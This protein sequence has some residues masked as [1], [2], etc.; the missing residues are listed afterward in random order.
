M[1]NREALYEKIKNAPL[2]A[3]LNRGQV[4][5]LLRELNARLEVLEKGHMIFPRTEPIDS[6]ALILSGS[7]E[8]A[9]HDYWG[10]RS[11]ILTQEAGESIGLPST[12][13][14]GWALPADVVVRSRCEL[15]FFEASKLRDPKYAAL[16]ENALLNTN[17]AKQLAFKNRALL[18]KISLVNRRSIR[19]K[20]SLFLS[21]K[22]VQCRSSS[23]DIEFTRQEMADFLSVNRCALSK[24]L[25]R[26]QSDGLI[27]YDHNHFE[28][29]SLQ[30]TD[31]YL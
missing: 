29:K 15:L 16:T 27:E 1:D 20:V 8:L 19:E 30:E 22:A 12:L 9:Q 24:E 7:A 11:I 4:L 25:A 21:Q 31:H 2:F 23:F 5:F 3:G 14:E 18:K 13:L 10:N 26:M 6:F 28:L 17:I